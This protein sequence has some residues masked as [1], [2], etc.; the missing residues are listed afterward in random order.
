MQAPLSPT[1]SRNERRQNH[2]LCP[3]ASLAH[4][5]IF[6]PLSLR[7]V[8]Y[9]SAHVTRRMEVITIHPS[10]SLLSL[11]QQGSHGARRDHYE[12]TILPTNSQAFHRLLSHAIHTRVL[13]PALLP[14]ALQ[15]IRR[16]IFPDDA[17]GP[18]RVPPAD[19]EVVAIKRECARVIVEVVPPYVRGKYFAT[20]DGAA[21]RDDVESSL[22]L[23]AD[24]FVNKHLVVEIVELV[25]L[26]LFPEIGEE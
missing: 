24:S 25:F 22:E 3:R 26:R 18:A 4:T 23:F 14:P 6:R 7:A 15:A 12:L 20:Q 10:S 5:C 8:A 19:D 21:M 16:A 2:T 11:P 13:D 17:L 9:A 1:G